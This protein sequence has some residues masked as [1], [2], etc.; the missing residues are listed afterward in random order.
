MRCMDEDIVQDIWLLSNIPNPSL[1]T[2]HRGLVLEATEA[3]DEQTDEIRR[4]F[5]YLL[6]F[7][8]SIEDDK[9]RFNKLRA[10]THITSLGYMGVLAVRNNI[11]QE[12]FIERA[13]AFVNTNGAEATVS[14]RYNKASSIG[15]T[16]TE[17]VK[18]R[19]DE[20]KK[21]IGI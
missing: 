19:M 14:D 17:Q 15:V 4:A 16:Q 10:K 11:S 20:I 1:S 18:T 12:N 9:K 2:K 21:Y 7:Y 3:T 8:K 5:D 6:S 13:A